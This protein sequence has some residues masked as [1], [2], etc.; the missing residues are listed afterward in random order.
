[1]SNTGNRFLY[2]TEFTNITVVANCDNTEDGSIE[3]SGT[4]F[5]NT[6][7]EYDIS[8]PGVT[9]EDSI[10]ASGKA[11]ITST[12]PSLN[13]ST[14]ALIVY[15]GVSVIKDSRYYGAFYIHNTINS[16]DLSSGSLLID[17]GASIF[18]NLNV[19][20]VITLYNTTNSINS[21]VGSLIS[22]GGISIQNTTDALSITS[23]GALTVAGG[24][25][26]EKTLFAN[27]LNII[28]ATLGSAYLTNSTINNLYTPYGYV[29]N[30]TSGNI[31]T[32]NITTSSLLVNYF[33]GISASISNLNLTYGTLGNVLISSQNVTNSTITSLYSSTA[34]VANL[35][36]T[37]GNI[38]NLTVGNLHVNT[39]IEF[40]DIVTNLSTA[41]ILSQYVTIANA[42]FTYSTFANLYAIDGYITNL[43]VPNL[44]S[45]NLS[46]SNL[47]SYNLISVYSTSGNSFITNGTIANILSNN[48]NTTNATA[49]NLYNTNLT[50]SNIHATNITSTSVIS[51]NASSAYSTTGYLNLTGTI[52]SF[53]SS[54]G[55]FISYGGVSIDIIE[56]ATSITSGGG[57]TVAGGASIAKDVYIGYTLYVPNISSSN[58]SGI[59]GT[60]SHLLGTNVNFVNS[61]FNNLFLTGTTPSSNSSSGTFISF[62]GI[63]INCTE[64]V[65][66]ITSGGGLTISGGASIAK[67]L[68]VGETFGSNTITAGVIYATGSTI[69][70]I[71]TTNL[72]G[73]N[74]LIT[75][76]SNT[77]LTTNSIISTNISS[78]NSTFTNALITN[79]T[80]NT[81][82]FTDIYFTNLNGTSI[83]TNS[84]DA[85]YINNN[86]SLTSLTGSITNLI[87]TTS[88]IQN[89]KLTN[90]TFSNLIGSYIDVNNASVSSLV[91]TNILTTNET[92]VNLL[93]TNITTTNLIGTSANIIYG[94]VSNLIGTNLDYTNSTIVNLKVS[95]IVSTSV[96]ATYSTIGTLIASTGTFINNSSI[97]NTLGNIYVTGTESSLN[98]TTASVTIAG[99]LSL[100]TTTN[101]TSSTSG[102]GLTVSGGLA[103]SKDTYIG[104]STWILGN[105]DLNSQLI[106]NVTAPSNPLEVA[107]KYYVDNRFNQYTIGNVN[108]NFTQGQVIIAST[109]GNITGYSE[110]MY[111][112]NQGALYIYSTNDSTSVSQGGSL[113]VSGGASVDKNFYVGGNAHVLGTLDMNNQKITSV[114]IPTTYYD[115]AN[116]Y[117]VDNRFNEFTIGNVSGNFTQGQVIVASTLGNITGFDTFTFFNNTLSVFTTNEATSLTSGGVLTVAGGARIA[118][119]L[120]IGG[121]ILQIPTGNISERPVNAVGGT[122]RYNTE[123]QQFEG[124]GAGNNWGSLGGVV[125][126]AQTTKILASASPSVTDGNLYFY[127]VGS[128]RV[129]INS[130]GNVGIGTSAPTK[131]LTISGDLLVTNGI[132]AGGQLITN[133]TAPSL[134]LDVVNKW[135]LDQRFDQYT[136][137][138]VSGNFTQG[139]VIVASTLG[140][141][142]GFDS[143]TFFDNVLSVLTTVDATSL[144]SGGVFSVSGG[145]R[146]QKNLYIGGQ[147]DVNGQL[148]TNA[149][150]PSVDLDVVNK[151]Y[152]DQRF[153]Q[154]T[155]GN[156]SGNF[157]Q[158]QVIVATTAGN[159]VG[160]DSFTFDQTSLTIYTTDEATS[161]TSG[162]VLNLQ[163]GARIAKSLY[164]GGPV[165]RIPTGDIL[166]RPIN[167]VGGEIRYNTETQQFEGFGAGN[168]WGSLGGVVDIAQ[169]TK[170]L[171]SASPS[172]TDGNLYFYTVG[173]ERVR[174]NSSGNVGIGTSAPTKTLTISGDLLVTSG[175]DAGGQLITNATAPSLDLDVVNK[176]YL[177]QRFEQYTIGNVSGNFTQGQVIVASTL[178]NITGFD[179]FTF[180]D[181]TLSVLTTVEATSLTSGGVFSVSGG[182]RIA[183]SL[184]IGGPVLQ[185]PTGDIASRPINTVGGEIRYNTETQQ[186]EGFG[187]GNNWGSLGGVV[188]IAQTTKIL[189]SAS[190][191]V[192]DGNLYFYTVGS[193]RVRINSA[194]NVGIGTTAPSARLTVSGDLLVTGGINGGGQII[195]NVTAPSLDMDVVNKWYLDDRLNQYTIGNVNGNFT[196]GQVIIASTQGNITGYNSFMFDGTKLSLYTTE[197]ALNLTSGGVLGIDGGV[198]IAKDVYI[199]GEVD[200]NFNNIKS[201]LDPVDDYDAVNKKYLETQIEN[202]F[203]PGN[204]DFF[205][206]TMELDNN[207]TI[208]ENIPNFIISPTAKAFIAKIYASNSNTCTLYTL[209]GML[210][211]GVWTLFHSFIG[212]P[213]TYFSFY[214]S[215][216]YIQY[217]NT[218]TTYYTTIRYGFIDIIETASNS[219]QQNVSLLGN[220]SSFQDISQLAF[221]S[222]NAVKLIIYISSDIDGKYGLVILDAVSKNS[223]WNMSSY[224]I[225]NIY[226]TIKFNITNTGVI[227]YINYSSSSDYIIRVVDRTLDNLTTVYTLNSNT[228]NVAIDT[229]GTILESNTN[230]WFLMSVYVYI[231]TQN[232]Y[233]FYEIEGIYQNNTWYINS[234]FIGDNTGITFQ[235][236]SINNEDYL[237]Y[238]NPNNN[239]AY[240]RI[241]NNVPYSGSALSVSKGGTGTTY[242][243]EYAVLRGNGSDA[244]IASD[245]FIYNNN[246]L[247]LGNLSSI[248]LTNT[249][250]SI[251]STSGTLVT[252]GGISVN[253]NILVNNVDITPSDDDIIKERVFSG[254]NN[255]TTPQDVVGLSFSNTTKSFNGTIC[256]TILTNTNE[257][258]SLFELKGL[259]KS[260]GWTLY[261]SFVGDNVGIT[262]IM[263]SSGQ[264]RYTS[265]NIPD[266]V[267]TTMKFK[268]LTTSA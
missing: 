189:A 109:G 134:D 175:I 197:N 185:I 208:P 15:G 171:A 83:Y 3:A 179:S 237:L 64:N 158:G 136:I 227:Q 221:T 25:S 205:Q 57:L 213:N 82:R 210:N 27:L 95:D 16:F 261:P 222:F 60:V 153:N 138:N 180:F 242:L 115:A 200:V 112:V 20:G 151:W 26:I 4:L 18:K 102:G 94:T 113:Q 8:S 218:D 122:I 202:I 14:A 195:T 172:V 56:N 253:K 199:G 79:V 37:Q 157:T 235:I 186:F 133:A 65:K 87:S 161:L 152:L 62:G 78:S 187:A 143:F 117:Y 264:V 22:L 63:S 6:I 74:A 106:T 101:A 51:V 150:A 228:A 53:N 167:T 190:P 212:E 42:L 174:I 265:S 244:I 243:N 254:Q 173:S 68:L 206:Y 43:T 229:L 131:T 266:W 231:P 142:T 225:G 219:L 120:Y 84:L 146:I 207:V 203:T 28:N 209:R 17:G 201:V 166:S 125:D 67:T 19:G 177:D 41:N 85:N 48:V 248:I 238:T 39:N 170:I 71:L 188:D 23:G 49:T 239:T 165:L 204:G 176:W 149:T 259:K 160:Y 252:Y 96:Y 128:E 260:A 220:V 90:G 139:Q 70:N 226:D 163:G 118:K 256:I 193:E 55:T 178:G 129:R 249:G 224:S 232:L 194:G 91:S 47:S 198:T 93:A 119:S 215:N 130:S 168:N 97:F 100:Q 124:F 52:P 9:L 76:I 191:S 234:K 233:A 104:G 114:A 192:T 258:D 144:T 13:I 137:G 257:F 211:N 89:L 155:I 145:A 5:V 169:T 35:L 147:L 184:Y 135:Y 34:N 108:G 73:S 24:A 245:D 241:I 267:S 80:G 36:V 164:I 107:N 31:I 247:I 98:S 59:Y 38:E 263:N 69:T 103:V 32:N 148:I 251:N 214:I 61:T 140:N 77:N 33:E 196:Q 105:L 230:T 154:Y 183:K 217:T 75:N 110:F 246:K 132:D 126:I 72:S 182:A 45:T 181:N 111:D 88:T 262:F 236:T 127:T 46:T 66:S 2:G 7:K 10:F 240:I 159:I 141:I 11:I 223:S 54:T 81:L 162:G 250:E 92:T 12:E 255:Q 1:M 123:T 86:I 29:Q 216:G 156:V 44:L 268:A 21:S 40:N 116:K 99:G 58:I 50:S 121:P 30:L